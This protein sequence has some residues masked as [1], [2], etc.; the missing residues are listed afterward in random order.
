MGVSRSMRAGERS[1]IPTCPRCSRQ[2]QEADPGCRAP[3]PPVTWGSHFPCQ[4][5]SNRHPAI[6]LPGE[7]ESTPLP[8][9]ILS[10]G[11]GDLCSCDWGQVPVTQV[12][13]ATRTSGQCGCR[14]PREQPGRAGRG[15]L[16]PSLH[17]GLACSHVLASAPLCQDIA[18]RGRRQAMQGGLESWSGGS[19]RGQ[20]L[21]G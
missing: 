15:L 9:S 6:F 18:C 2:V 4:D 19:T 8:L 17:H 1:Q 3:V 11:T 16:A 7:A 5:S 20:A 21:G 14:K 13:A 12:P 10:A